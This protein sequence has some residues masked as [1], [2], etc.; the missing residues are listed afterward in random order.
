M[1]PFSPSHLFYVAKFGWTLAGSLK[2]G[3]VLVL[4]NSELVT[5]EWIQHEI[6]ESPI[7]VCEVLQ[8]SNKFLLRRK[9]YYGY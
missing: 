6:L 1:V 4:S 3:D 2:T 8:L 7:K 5:V 9:M